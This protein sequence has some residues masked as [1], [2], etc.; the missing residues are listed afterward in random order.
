MILWMSAE[1]MA[2]VGESYQICSNAI[3]T[4]FNELISEENLLPLIDRWSF[5]AMILNENGPDYKEV[6][7]RSDK[8]KEFEFR[9]KISH[10]DFKNGNDAQRIEL[11]IEALLCA[12]DLMVKF[13]VS[14]EDREKL[15]ELLYKTKSELLR[16]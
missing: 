5:I 16:A 3:E 9:I 10:A 11:V 6:V 1:L 2:D 8:G 7:R 4:K 13:K 15:K 12:V 14:P